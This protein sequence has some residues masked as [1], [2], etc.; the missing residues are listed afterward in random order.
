MAEER[1]IKP[2][3]RYYNTYPSTVRRWLNIYREK[4]IDGLKNNK[5]EKK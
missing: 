2:V 5:N 3:A 4:G 1:G